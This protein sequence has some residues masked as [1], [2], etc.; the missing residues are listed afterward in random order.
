MQA[1]DI[2]ALLE[3]QLANTNATVNVMGS[4][5]DITI[6][7]D[8][9]AGVSRVKKQQMVYAAIAELIASGEVHAVDFIKAYTRA[10]WDQLA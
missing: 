1:Q 7:G 5:I 3:Q 10:E 2:E 6:V 4:H 8:V 9:F